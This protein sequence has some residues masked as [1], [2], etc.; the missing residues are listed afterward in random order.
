MRLGHVGHAVR[1]TIHGLRRDASRSAERQADT[2]RR[3]NYGSR[4]LDFSFRYSPSH[5]QRI[6]AR[7]PSLTRC[8]QRV[9]RE[10]TKS[11]ENQRLDT[12]MATLALS[13]LEGRLEN[14]GLTVPIPTFPRAD[15]LN[16][17]LDIARSYL[18]QILTSAADCDAETAYNATECTNNIENGDLAV[19]IRKLC[20]H[21]KSDEVG[22]KI[23]DKVNADLLGSMPFFVR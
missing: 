11:N 1:L 12:A 2:L 8:H 9:V 15:V 19:V 10:I 13:G 22:F 6:V 5:L 16:K 18:A 17:P 4:H 23:A 3:D 7:E 14:L 20:P 21:D